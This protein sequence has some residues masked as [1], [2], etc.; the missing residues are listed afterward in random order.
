MAKRTKSIGTGLLLA[1]VA[2]LSIIIFAIAMRMQPKEGFEV[3]PCPSIVTRDPSTNDVVVQPGGRR[4]K[5]VAAYAAAMAAKPNCVIMRVPEIATAPAPGAN[6]PPYSKTDIKI[7]QQ[8][9]RDMAAADAVASANGIRDRPFATSPIDDVTDY[10]DTSA[11]VEKQERIGLRQNEATNAADARMRD[12]SSYPT[13]SRKYEEGR[14]TF[15]EQ[16]AE[17]KNTLPAGMVADVYARLQRSTALPPDEEKQ[18]VEERAALLEYGPRSTPSYWETPLEDVQR[19]INERGRDGKFKETVERIGP[20]Q[21]AI[22]KITPKRDQGQTVAYNA[23]DDTAARTADT[24][25]Y[26]PAGPAV[27]YGDPFFEKATAAETGSVARWSDFTRWTPGLERM[28]APSV[29]EVNWY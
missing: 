21:F 18:E 23:A 26:A 29:P 16:Q 19:L 7:K 4:Y 11:L 22:T 5:S 3:E 15:A 10:D 8:A 13:S 12:W 1:I 2:I 27:L 24:P 17:G 25:I 9:R 6:V 14:A 20:N 28:F